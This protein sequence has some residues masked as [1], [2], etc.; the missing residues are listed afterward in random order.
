MNRGGRVRRGEQEDE[1]GLKGLSPW[2]RQRRRHFLSAHLPGAVFCQQLS[3]SLRGGRSLRQRVAREEGGG[4]VSRGTGGEQVESR[5][6]DLVGFLDDSWY[7]R[8][9]KSQ[10]VTQVNR[11]EGERRKRRRRRK[12]GEGSS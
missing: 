9:K 12:T 6:R 1:D 10:V 8:G 2:K 4:G 3:V 11:R 7:R 5:K